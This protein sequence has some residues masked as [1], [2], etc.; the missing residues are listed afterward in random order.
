MTTLA[1]QTKAV[2]KLVAEM[3]KT[4]P[5][6]QRIALTLKKVEKTKAEKKAAKADLPK[7][8]PVKE[9]LS[10]S[11]LADHLAFEAGTDRKVV[12]AILDSLKNVAAG[13]LSK[14]GCGEFAIPGLLKLRAKKVPA[15]VRKAIP[16]GTK[17][18]SPAKKEWVEHAG[19][20]AQKMPATVRVVARPATVLRKYALS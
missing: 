13:A 16:A 4:K 7:V 5:M 2:Q 12:L 6:A 19:R 1:S 9:K 18:Y 10:K 14:K 15:R 8:S 17:V 20:P 3:P 11:Q